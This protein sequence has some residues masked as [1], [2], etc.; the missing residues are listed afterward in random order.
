[1]LIDLA[2]TVALILA[3]S[4]LQGHVRRRLN[5]APLLADVASGLMFG[6]VCVVGMTLPIQLAQGVLIDGRSVVLSM[7]GLF[8]G[9]VVGIISGAIA[10]AYRLWL[11]G[12]G[13]ISGEAVIVMSV[14]AGVIY[15][16]LC[17]RGHLSHG[18]V[19][20][21]MFGLL[22]H[23]LWML[24]LSSIPGLTLADVYAKL[25][26]AYLLI[27]GAAT[28]LLGLLLK[29]EDERFRTGRA[30]AKS[31][32]HLQAIMNAI[33]DILFVLDHEGRYLDVRTQNDALLYRDKQSVIGRLAT[34]I[35]PQPLATWLL[36][37]IHAAITSRQMRTLQYALDTPAGHK[38]FEGT[39]QAIDRHHDEI[40]TVILVVRDVSER[41][42]MEQELRIAA[43][44]FESQQGMLVTDPDTHILRVNTAF[45]RITGYP[46]DEVIGKTPKVL[47]SGRN[48]PALYRDMWAQLAMHKLWEGEVWNRR[49][50]G[51]E[52]PE[53]LSISAVLNDAG[54]VTHYVGS[55]SDVSLRKANEAEIHQLA[56]YDHLTGLPNRLML[57][58]R[59]RQSLSVSNRS[60]HYGA[61][62]FIDLDDFKNIN[63]VH[64]HQTGDALLKETAARLSKVVRDSDTVA[65][66]G[67]D[68]FVILLEQ[69]SDDASDAGTAAEQ[70]A[71]KVLETVNHPY[72]ID[73]QL[74]KSSASIGITLFNDSR[75]SVDALMQSADLS[76]YEAKRSGKNQL[77]FFD[78]V[79]QRTVSDRLTLEAELRHA[80]ERHEFELHYQAQCDAHGRVHGA[81]ALARWRHPIRGLVSPGVF[82]PAAEHFGL[83]PALGAQ[84]LE[85][86]CL[87]LGRWA[88]DPQFSALRL[89]V[90]ISAVQLYL[91]GFVDRVRELIDRSGFPPGKLVLEL[92]ETV[93]LGDITQAIEVMQALRAIGVEFSIDDF[94]T[95]YSSL[96]YLQ[97]LPLDELKIDRSFVRNLPH[98]ANSL[99]IVRSI[100]ALSKALNLRLIAEGVEEAAQI[101]ALVGNGCDGFQG[102][103]FAKPLQL[104]AFETHLA[105][106]QQA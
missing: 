101:E 98:S 100:V 84:V 28:M 50:S 22:I 103:Y 27:M 25:G 74:Y 5:A 95:G 91:P 19:A 29:D 9:P 85:Q 67:G 80:L 49:R 44:A 81:E 83:M 36:S 106:M 86:A 71:E 40:P 102:F 42:A 34:D 2:H 17:L 24:P 104:E 77:R 37:E 31:E 82:I 45:T 88:Q 18:P 53:H 4:L 60:H 105:K 70:V 8:G 78:P 47:S 89:S 62:M 43:I 64:G 20:L 12:A 61:L 72:L 10:A 32:A 35:L 30:L 93:L 15:R 26:P 7:A 11:G 79:M 14:V 51:E 38:V 58:D 66:F 97:R 16:A 23:A 33:P 6:V 75:Q 76:M 99:A 39:I 54:E 92:T 52:Y 41:V 57:L 21:F 13:L 94:G 73:D 59:L 46:A 1:M 87:Q 69:L 65:R 68:E 63:D 90:N 48:D 55:F 56:Y 96:A 3:L